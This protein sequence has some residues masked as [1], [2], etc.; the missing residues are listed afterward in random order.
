MHDQVSIKPQEAPRR[1]APLEAIPI[2]GKHTVSWQSQPTNSE[3]QDAVSIQRGEE[4]Y[5]INCAL[6]H[7]T[8]ATYPGAVGK[9]LI[10]P[11]P[12]LY[13]PRIS[14]LNDGDL[15]KRIALGFGRMPAFQDK[16]S[17]PDRWHLVNYLRTFH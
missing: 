8:R 17:E 11:P 2:Q 6:C 16:L 3:Q 4:L 13:D 1:S 14:A 10:P 5:Q 7:G 9:K 12:N 15:Y